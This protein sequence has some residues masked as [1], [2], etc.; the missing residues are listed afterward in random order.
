VNARECRDSSWWTM[1]RASRRSDRSRVISVYRERFLSVYP[2]S[3][4]LLAL[5]LL[6][7]SLCYRSRKSV[8][9]SESVG[10]RSTSVVLNDETSNLRR[11]E[12]LIRSHRSLS[13]NCAS[14]RVLVL[15]NS[16]VSSSKIVSPETRPVNCSLPFLGAIISSESVSELSTSKMVIERH[17]YR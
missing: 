1:R 7:L 11:P 12:Q 14:L 13:V 4:P 9:S 8:N 10:A 2:F 5:H 3:R 17:A 6:F 16:Y 15:R